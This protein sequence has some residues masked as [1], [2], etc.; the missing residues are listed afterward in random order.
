MVSEKDIEHLAELSRIEIK[1][2]QKEKLAHDLFEIVEYFKELKNADTGGI[3]PAEGG[4]MNKNALRDDRE[5]RSGFNAEAAR[6][7]FPEQEGGFLKVP[8]VFE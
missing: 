4:T 1:A 6:N 7:A 3:A 5:E 8:P 2:E